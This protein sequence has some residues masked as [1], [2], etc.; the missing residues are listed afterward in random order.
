MDKKLLKT[1]LCKIFSIH[2]GDYHAIKELDAGHIPLISCGDTDNGCIGYFDIPPQKTYSHCI[3]VAYN[4]SWPLLSKFHP[5][6][7][8]AK[9]DVA[10]LIPKKPLLSTTLLYIASLLNK[11]VW[12]YSYGRKCFRRKL[13]RFSLP[14]PMIDN[15]HIDEEYVSKMF[16]S[17]YRS[18][19][20]TKSNNGI[21]IIPSFK[22]KLFNIIEVFSIRRGD[23]HSIS[24]LDNGNCVTISRVSTDNGVVG[25]FEKPEDAIEYEKGCLTISTVGADTFVQLER[26]IATDNVIVCTPKKSLRITTLFFMAFI[27]NRQR[28]RYSYG[29][30]CYMNKVKKIAFHLPVADNGDLDEEGIAKVVEQS[31][32]WNEIKYKF[33]E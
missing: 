9:D 25:Y 20:P 12:R 17:E 7:F 13:E 26:F 31:E 2:S 6:I 3:T 14:L 8:G 21:D 19:I 1:N 30:Q 28:W 4:G 22:W 10:V 23:F 33:T 32:Y 29:R 24:D 18:F 5:Y 15:E 27:L 16:V 11:N